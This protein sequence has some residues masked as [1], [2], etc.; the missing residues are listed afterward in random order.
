MWRLVVNEGTAESNMALDE[1]ML[2]MKEKK[3]TPST[4]RLYTFTPSAVTIGYFQKIN[5]VVDLDF[6]REEGIPII[7]RITG[8]GAVFHDEYG[9]ITYSVTSTTDYFSSDVQESYREICGGL[10]YTLEE[11]GVK[12]KFEPINDVTVGGK[13]ISGSAQIRRGRVILQHGT[14]MYNTD[15]PKLGRLFKVPKE[16]LIAHGANTIF[17]RVTT[18]TREVGRTVT[19]EEVID[20]LKRGFSKAFN[21]DI[22]VDRVLDEELDLAKTIEEKYKSQAW[23]Y[24]R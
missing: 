23:N 20:A 18:L 12:A 5:E 14:F 22:M 11:F 2:I 16:K 9:E 7:R 19:K 3:T 24:R 6:A 13:K 4:L 10:V 21:S 15:I 1:A 17:D 8:G